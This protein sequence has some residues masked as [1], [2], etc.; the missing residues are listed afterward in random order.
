MWEDYFKLALDGMA[1]R[2]LRSWLTMMGVFIGIMAVVTLISLGQGLQHYIDRQFEKVGGDRIAIS[3]GGGGIMNSAPGSS[4]SSAKLGDSDLDTVRK[5]RG[6][7]FAVGVIMQTA[8]VE[9]NKKTKYLMVQG[10]STDSKYFQFF[11]DAQFQ[12]VETGTYLKKGDKYKALIGPALGIDRFEKDMRVGSKIL[13]NNTEFTVAGVKEDTGNPMDNLRVV[14]PEDAA[15]E[16]FQIE[17][18]YATISVKVQKGYDPSDVAE[19]IKENLRRHRNVKEKEEDFSVTTAESMIASFKTVLSIVTLVL[20]GIAAISLF[21]GGVGI[22]TTMY[23]SVIER[24]R[25]IGVM[26]SIGA[27]NND[28]LLIFMAES[29]LL[30]LVGG[31]IGIILGLAASF[32]GEKIVIAYGITEFAL[33]A[34]PDLLLGAMVFSILV[35]CAS[36][37]FPAMR[38]AK[39]KPVDALRYR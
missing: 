20:S 35:G 2:K 37:Y 19:N 31:I 30:G 27:R 26:K 16:V 34:G 4:M 8:S 23:T 1:N 36:G 13:I 28:I 21:V 17:D 7:E 12:N 32:V 33:Y 25:Q 11:K 6:V 5:T 38:A 22:M 39:M 9:Y 29:G 3:P 24:T 14:I 10:I 15:K 18:D